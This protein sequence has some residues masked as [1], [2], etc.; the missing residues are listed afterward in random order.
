[1]IIQK[2]AVVSCLNEILRLQNNQKLLSWYAQ[3]LTGTSHYFYL[4]GIWAVLHGSEF[5]P[6]HATLFFWH[7]IRSDGPVLDTII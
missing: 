6:V 7:E 4:D 5:N 2:E 1:M 3:C